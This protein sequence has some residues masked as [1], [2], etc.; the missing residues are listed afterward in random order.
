MGSILFGEPVSVSNN[1]SVP[2][3]QLVRAVHAGQHLQHCLVVFV[4]QKSNTGIFCRSAF[5]YNTADCNP[6]CILPISGQAVKDLKAQDR[7]HDIW[8]TRGLVHN[9]LGI[10]TAW[11]TI[12]TL[13][14]LAVV[15]S[16]SSHDIGV[17]TASIVALVLLTSKLVGFIVLDLLVLDR[18]SRFNFTPYIVVVVA[19][20]GS[21][22]N[23]WDP[24]TMLFAFTAFLL[25]LSGTACW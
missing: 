25:G 13:L 24:D 10:Y 9:G 20:S 16:Y 8:L 14:N 18:F 17:V 2:D 21:I 15:I 11:A 1:T 23:N 12:A 19:L 6:G 5:E 7:T 4:R 22:A 3:C